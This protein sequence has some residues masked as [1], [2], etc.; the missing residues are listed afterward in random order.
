MFDQQGVSPQ[1]VWAS[2]D[3]IIGRQA[4]EL[5]KL[6]QEG[7]PVYPNFT[8]MGGKGVDFN[9]E[10][11]DLFSVSR[12]DIKPTDARRID[13]L[14]KNTAIKKETKNGIKTV[15]PFKDFVG[16]AS[17]DLDKWLRGLGGG[18]RG[19]FMNIMSKGSQQYVMGIPDIGALRIADTAPDLLHTPIYSSGYAI[20][21]YDPSVGIIKNPV[22]PHSTYTSQLAGSPMGTFGVDLPYELVYRD[23][24]KALAEKQLTKPS[25]TPYFHATTG[26]VT[27]I[28]K[29]DQEWVDAL[30]QAIENFRKLKEQQ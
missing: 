20:G 17:P 13:S 22:K 9:K 11:S 2:S 25:L 16:I 30:S 8:V 19:L 5:N 18:Q 29:A 1:A 6:A 24:A 27:P 23:W 4:N 14:I 12:G 7:V 3:A 28:Q 15:Y 10:M 26:G 21:R